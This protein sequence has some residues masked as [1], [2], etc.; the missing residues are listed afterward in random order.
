MTIYEKENL[1]GDYTISIPEY[2]YAPIFFSSMNYDL[3]GIKIFFKN[4]TNKEISEKL[5]LS[6]LIHEY[7]LNYIKNFLKIK[8]LEIK[9]LKSIFDV[10]EIIYEDLQAFENKIS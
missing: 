2:E 7:G 3:E 5:F 8:K 4:K 6:L 10:K 1:K 9:N